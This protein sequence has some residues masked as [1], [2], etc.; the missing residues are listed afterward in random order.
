MEIKYWVYETKVYGEKDE[1]VQAK[2]VT[3]ELHAL[4]ENDCGYGFD[5]P[6]QDEPYGVDLALTYQ[7]RA[8]FPHVDNYF[9]SFSFKLYSTR[10]AELM[11]SFG[12]KS[13]TFPV[14]MVDEHGKVQ[15]QLK[16][17]IFHSLEGTLDA[18]DEV[19]SEW[20]G[21]DDIGIPRL[22]LDYSKFEHRPIFT[23]DKVFVE[24]MRDDLK[25]EI[26][27]RGITGFSFLAPER[28]RCGEQGFAP[29]F[30]D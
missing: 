23:C 17:V 4:S 25:Q 22:I 1:Y 13:E 16:Y 21:N 6:T 30:E 3:P 15:P 9:E 8:A 29:D 7:I 20:R 24:L 27:R 5:S 14:T 18:M 12:V 2:L 10:L 19:K 11:L 26:Q 28:Y